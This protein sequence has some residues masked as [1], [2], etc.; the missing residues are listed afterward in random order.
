MKKISLVLTTCLLSVG[1]QV[2]D[3]YYMSFESAPGAEVLAYGDVALRGGDR[4]V[5]SS[6]IPISYKLIRERYTVLLNIDIGSWYPASFVKAVSLEGVE[7]EIVPGKRSCAYFDLRP[8]YLLPPY[9]RRGWTDEWHYGWVWGHSHSPAR[10]GS[11]DC[12]YKNAGDKPLM[13]NF[14][15]MDSIG[16]ILG[17]ESIPF[18]IH[19]NGIHIMSDSL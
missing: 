1:C 11:E 16:S 15:V 10:P 4:T 18:T 5:G 13:M 9:D 7:L 6:P 2:H 14:T 19:K 8:S 17:E 12:L 3:Y